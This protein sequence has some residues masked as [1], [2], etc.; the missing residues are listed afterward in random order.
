MRK[1]IIEKRRRARI[2]KSLSRLLD[3]LVQNDI[4]PQPSRIHKYDKADI[5]EMTVD[6]LKLE[7]FDNVI[8]HSHRQG[9]NHCLNE[10]V[11]TLKTLQIC[12]SVINDL[13]SLLQNKINEIYEQC[14]C[15]KK[16]Q[17]IYPSQPDKENMPP[18]NAQDVWR[19]W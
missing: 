1:P 13:T 19:P 2:N 4:C 10:T 16:P 9:F 8:F 7:K 3:F 11:S 6:Y 15:G 18:T 17:R 5:L 14:S 12:D